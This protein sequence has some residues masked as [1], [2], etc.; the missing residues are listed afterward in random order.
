MD[1]LTEHIVGLSDAKRAL[2]ELQLSRRYPKKSATQRIPRLANRQAIPL[3]FAQQRLWFLDQLEPGSPVYNENVAVRILGRLNVSALR[4]AIDAIVARHEVLRTTFVAVG[5]VPVQMIGAARPIELKITDLSDGPHEQNGSIENLLHEESTRPFSLSTDLM[6][7]ASLL[8]LAPEEHILFVVMHHISMDG[9][10][11]GL[12]FQELGA[13]YKAFSFGQPSPLVD[14][15]V[16]YADYAVWQREQLSGQSLAAELSY[17]KQQLAGISVLDLPTEQ[18]R[19]AIQTYTGARQSFRLSNT[20]TSS[21]KALSR[22]E[23]VTL[24]ATLLAAFKTLL[25]RYTQCD[26]IVVGSPIAGRNRTEIEGLIGLFINNLVLRT[27]FSGEP[28]FR[29]L[30]SRVWKVALEAYK[31]QNLPFEKL[32]EE[33]QPDRSLSYSAL[34]QVMFVLQPWLT[35]ELPGLTVVPVVVNDQTAKFDLTLSLT[36]ESGSLEGFFEYNTDL[37]DRVTVDRMGGHFQTLLRAV[38]ANPEQRL[39]ELRFLSE[40]EGRQLL[41]E[42]NDTQRDY[43]KGKCIHELFEVQAER[44]ADKVEDVAEGDRN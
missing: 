28:N 3:S 19:P 14:L 36:E 26:D 30:L 40:A 2:L 39:S 33:L 29:E 17:W 24:F 32:V 35:I 18:P 7:R 27:D 41:V 34:F 31:H 20:L 4:R 11:V 38:V 5:G 42:W 10:S 43:P 16:Q 44:I 22:R 13:L 23:G 12:L 15:P 25:Y 1:D 8:R 6:L 9:W 21:V 37:F